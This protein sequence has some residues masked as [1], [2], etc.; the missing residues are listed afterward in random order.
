MV[1]EAGAED[2]VLIGEIGILD[3][4]AEAEAEVEADVEGTGR[5]DIEL[6]RSRPSGG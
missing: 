4:E 2:G 6:L 5:V 1:R 3:V